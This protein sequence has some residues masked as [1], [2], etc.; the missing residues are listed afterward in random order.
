MAAQKC[1]QD[2]VVV[3]T[4][5]GR[6]IGRGMAMLAA[7]EGAKVVV[8]DLGGSTDGEGRDTSPA[9]DVVAEIKKAG[10]KAVANY[11]SVAEAESAQKIVQTRDRQFRPHRQRRQQRRHPARP[12]LPPHERGRLR[13][14]HQGPLDGLVLHGARRRQPLQGAELRLLRALH[15]DIRPDRQLRPGELCRRQA[16]HRRSVARHRARHGRASTCAPTA[17]RRSPGAA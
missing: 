14:G 1:M 13:N 6:G 3:V 9:D 15:L 5:A 11:D 2:K 12:H 7:A 4:G 17:S 16:R 10:G 8:N